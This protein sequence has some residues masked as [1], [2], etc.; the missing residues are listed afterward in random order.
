MAKGRSLPSIIFLNTVSYMM[1]STV[2]GSMASQSAVVMTLFV[3]SCSKKFQDLVAWK[4]SMPKM[5]YECTPSMRNLMA[6]EG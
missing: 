6:T 1:A 3:R 2:S 5:F 4:L